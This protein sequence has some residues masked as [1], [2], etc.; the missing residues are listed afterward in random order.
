MRW[1]DV[2]GDTG[3]RIE[4]CAGTGCATFVAAGQVAG[5]ITTFTDSG[6]IATTLYR[7]R[8]RAFNTGG[9]SLPS[10]IAEMTTLPNTPTSMTA[11]TVSATQINLAWSATGG[12]GGFR[13]ERCSGAGCAGFVQIAQTAPTVTSFANGTLSS[14]MLYRYRV[15][16]FT[17]SGQ[18]AYSNT[19]EATTVPAT[20]TG[21][22]VTS[23]SATQITVR[24]TDV[25]G[26]TGVRI[27]RCAG[28]ACATFAAVGEVAGNVTTFVDS[29]V[30]TK[31]LYRYRVRAFNAGGDPSRRT[32]W[33]PLLN[34]AHRYATTL[35][36]AATIAVR[37]VALLLAVLGIFQLRVTAQTPAYAITDLGTLGGKRSVARDINASAQVVGSSE[38]SDGSTHAFLYMQGSMLDLGT[39]GGPTSIAH[40]ITDSGLIAGRAQTSTGRYHPFL[41][42]SG[43]RL[44]DPA[45]FDDRLNGTF[46]EA[47]GVNA[48]GQAV[49]YY[50]TSGDHMAARNRVFLYQDFSAVDLGAFGGDDGIV[51]SINRHGHVV[52]YVGTE[53]HADYSNQRSFFVA[54]GKGVMLPTLGGRTTV[55]LALNDVGQTVGHGQ[56][57]SGERHA[58][59]YSKGILTDLGTL[60]GGHQSFAYGLNNNGE[61]VGSAEAGQGGLRAVLYRSGRI[62]DLNTLLP[63]H[64]GWVLTEARAINAAGQIVG[65]G[66][67]DGAEHAFLLTPVARPGSAVR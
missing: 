19:A 15:R 40:R 9:D 56:T 5:N 37:H 8:A 6:V 3:V 55:A 21:L 44:F 49:G 62:V 53:Q 29:S 30:T 48:A 47:L 7:Y 27:E 43:G 46:S 39:F 31:M 28:S 59:L 42:E 57:S 50:T 22:V 20:P 64:S 36:T 12:E 16:A 1:N 17:T 11:T 34:E 14:G 26:D 4:R 32:P 63:V 58:F 65:T 52:G 25:A 13:I 45:W 41:S 18:S 67:I 66:I 54:E 24:W 2:A 61:V 23:A 10:N 35:M 38:T 51:T 33:K 60:P